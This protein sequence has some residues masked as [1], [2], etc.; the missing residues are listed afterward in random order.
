VGAWARAEPGTGMTPVT[1]R[2][3]PDPMS[4]MLSQTR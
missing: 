4:R 3:R 1:N 2:Q